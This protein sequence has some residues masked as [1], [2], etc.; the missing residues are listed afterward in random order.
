MRDSCTGSYDVKSKWVA[1]AAR[2]LSPFPAV[3]ALVGGGG[4]TTLL[5]ALG[6]YLH[7]SGKRVLLSTTT[8][9]YPPEPGQA[10]LWL[11][12][13]PP[14]RDSLCL[15][16]KGI[17][18]EGKVEGLDAGLFS[19]LKTDY[20]VILVEADGSRGLPLKFWGQGEPV[21]PSGVT[22]IFCLASLQAFA[23]PVPEVLHR[24]ERADEYFALP[25]QVDRELWNALRQYHERTLRQL[26]DDGVRVRLIDHG[27]LDLWRKV[28][29]ESYS[30]Y[31]WSE[32]DG[33]FDQKSI[34]RTG[35]RT[36]QRIEIRKAKRFSRRW[37]SKG[38]VTK[39]ER[40]I[41]IAAVVLAAGQA[42]RFGGG[43]LRAPL[44]G[45]P[46]LAW[47]L[48]LI[49]SIPFSL[50][51]VVTGAD[52]GIEELAKK[53]GYTAV[54]NQDWQK[55][56]GTSLA[57]GVQALLSSRSEK[58]IDGVLFF[59]GDMPLIQ[60]KT[61]SYLLQQIRSAKPDIAYPTYRGKK[62]HPVY[63]Q[64]QCFS[65]L[66]SLSGNEGG[67]QLMAQFSNQLTV[68]VDDKGVLT[69]VDSQKELETVSGILNSKWDIK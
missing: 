49:N 24:A 30:A 65:E 63:F 33:C 32:E 47:T 6:R 4:K 51:L 21:L 27:A 45:R 26:V 36:K 52:F 55:G 20:D 12:S 5:Y 22:D 38:T 13:E 1:E 17:S 58:E 14:P 31:L 18:P 60:R 64:R 69:D 3:V 50:R 15:W 59:L 10:S 2:L 35:K 37:D 16:G 57:T 34:R 61:V 19:T 41:S 53:Y 8:K 25:E 11:G 46:L 67:R 39:G 54:T 62:G 40:E 42:S 7:Q 9:M 44:A 43:K 28:C 56:M 66:A 23:K 68:P 48:R 29:D